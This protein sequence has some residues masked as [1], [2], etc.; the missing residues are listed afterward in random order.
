MEGRWGVGKSVFFTNYANYIPS[1]V[2][3]A[4]S[5]KLLTGTANRLS[6]YYVPGVCKPLCQAFSNF[7]GSR[8]SQGKGGS[9]F[10]SI[11]PPATPPRPDGWGPES[12]LFFKIGARAPRWLT[13]AQSLGHIGET[14]LRTKSGTAC[15]IRKIK[16]NPKL[17]TTTAPFPIQISTFNVD[18]ALQ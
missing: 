11:I 15:L 6:A 5:P 9:F 12:F 8:H 17:R 14:M 1:Q 2:W 13:C 4:K 3:E 18:K 16:M 7:T 10:P